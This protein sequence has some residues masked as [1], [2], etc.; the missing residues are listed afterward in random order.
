MK[1]TD[2]KDSVISDIEDIEEIY[3]EYSSNY[4]TEINNLK[5]DV[6]NAHDNC[7]SNLN[8]YSDSLTLQTRKGFYKA[9]KTFPT[10]DDKKNVWM[11]YQ[12]VFPAF[13]DGEFYYN[14][15][16]DDLEFL[17]NNDETS[18][19]E[20]TFQNRIDSLNSTIDSIINDINTLNSE[21][22][23]YFGTLESLVRA[24]GMSALMASEDSDEFDKTVE[25]KTYSN[26]SLKNNSIDAVKET[27]DEY[28]EPDMNVIKRKIVDK[29]NFD[30]EITSHYNNLDS[31]ID[32]L[33]N[34]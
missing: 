17:L 7:I 14:R 19:T 2:E 1:V 25:N 10:I 21:V 5:N 11:E 22:S 27:I 3:P 4:S 9:S 33:I 12:D 28:G 26:N 31:Y 8:T 20:V 34:G 24:L 13:G 15:M 29:N 16:G 30:S 32:N 18:V 23:N 6:N